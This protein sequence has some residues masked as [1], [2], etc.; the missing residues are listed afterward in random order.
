[1][2]S[3]IRK[4]SGLTTPIRLRSLQLNESG[5]EASGAPP[6]KKRRGGT[7]GPITAAEATP[8]EGHASHSDEKYLVA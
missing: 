3:R 1:G 8:Y 5:V 6:K 4:I 7:N 2:F